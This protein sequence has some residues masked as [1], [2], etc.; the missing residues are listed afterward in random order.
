VQAGQATATPKT[1]T[2]TVEMLRTLHVAHQTA[3]KARTQTIN[4]LHN[5]LVTAPA[6]LREELAGLPARALIPAATALTPGPMTTPT[7]AYRLALRSLAELYTHLTA[8]L[9]QLTRQLDTLTTRHAP[10]LRARVG[11]G[12]D[13]TTTLLVSAGDNPTRLGSDAALAALYGA[14]PVQ[15]SSGRTVRHRLNRGGDR[16][17]NAA[18][19]RIV[20][21]RM[22]CDQRTRDYVARRTAQGKT[23]RE[24]IRCLKRYVARE[25]Y[26]LLRDLD[27]D[28]AQQPT[29]P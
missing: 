29:T 15:A 2:G 16:Q 11:F 12:P 6:D 22:R 27:T 19:Y 17:A 1:G 13:T 7:A 26:A 5:L 20:L 14:S 9:T 10:T 23:K 3:L 24:I 25:V 4:T 21:V 8:Q 28:P 18:L